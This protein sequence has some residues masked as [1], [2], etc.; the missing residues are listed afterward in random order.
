MSSLVVNSPEVEERAEVHLASAMAAAPTH[1]STNEEAATAPDSEA[2]A[3]LAAE[4]QLEQGS[5]F[6]D[7]RSTASGMTPLDE[8]A[9][10]PVDAP[11]ADAAVVDVKVPFE[12]TRVLLHEEKFDEARERLAQV[13]EEEPRN[14]EARALYHVAYEYTLIERDNTAAAMTQFEVA[15]KHD[16][17]C[18]HAATAAASA[19]SSSRKRQRR[20]SLLERIFRR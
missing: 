14:R 2:D 19:K 9:G 3:V 1:E 20:P 11:E 18:K 6:A 17:S 5:L 10:Q 4:S 16:P 12:E 15:L 7:A 8:R 13:L